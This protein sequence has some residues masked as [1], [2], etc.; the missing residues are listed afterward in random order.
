[1]PLEFHHRI[2]LTKRHRKLT[3]RMRSGEFLDLST[4]T[5]ASFNSVPQQTGE[6]KPREFSEPNGK[7][8]YICMPYILTKAL[9]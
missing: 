9:G 3:S 2:T 6:G 4:T 7:N 8:L 1:M 5:Q